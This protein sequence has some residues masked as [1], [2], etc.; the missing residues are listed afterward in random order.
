M[1][2]TA[3]QV[4]GT[5]A[6]AGAPAWVNPGRVTA[7]DASAADIAA[8]S[9]LPTQVSGELRATNFGFAAAGVG[10]ADTIDG[11]EMRFKRA[12]SRA[13]LND[14]VIKLFWTGAVHG[15]NKAKADTTNWDSPTG[16]YQFATYGS[17]A[18]TWGAGATGTNV[19]DATFGVS[20]T[21][22]N[23]NG[24]FGNRPEIDVVYMTI[25]F[26]EVA[27]GPRFFA[28]VVGILPVFVQS[29]LMPLFFRQRRVTRVA[30]LVRGYK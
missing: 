9:M 26:T 29:L 5:G 25:T 17:A 21:C 28:Q 7:E 11:V 20:I 12:A 18:D 19:R 2:S 3:E 30:Q 22:E 23:N 15:N 10:S 4:A 1:P 6:S 16:N 14:Q 24:V 27:V 13:S 8:A